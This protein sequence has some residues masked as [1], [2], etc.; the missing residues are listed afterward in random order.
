MVMAQKNLSKGMAY[1]NKNLQQ[2]MPAS[3][4]TSNFWQLLLHISVG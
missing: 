2:L 3:I 4:I 1:N